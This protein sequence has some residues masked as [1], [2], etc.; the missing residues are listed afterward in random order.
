MG[1]GSK[2][3]TYT[4]KLKLMIECNKVTTVI[5]LKLVQVQ[6]LKAHYFKII[7]IQ[8]ISI[9]GDHKARFYVMN[10]S[11]LIA[12]PKVVS[13]FLHRSC[14]V[15]LAYV[16]KITQETTNGLFSMVTSYLDC[17]HTRSYR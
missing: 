2:A 9:L 17:T 3:N 14:H 13:I 5:G 11:V 7:H 16:L 15:T 1:R 6:K 4:Q 10:L 8:V 12:V